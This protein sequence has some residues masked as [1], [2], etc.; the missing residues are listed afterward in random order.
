MLKIDN[1]QTIEGVQVYG[2]DTSLTKFYLLPDMP[3]FRINDDGIPAFTFLKYREP[4]DRPDGKKGGAFLVFDAEFVVADEKLVVIKAKLQEQ[5][6][7]KFPGWNPMPQVEIGTITW[8][9]GTSKLNVESFGDNFVEKVFNPGKP[10]LYGRNI[11]PFSV[12]LTVDGAQLFEAALQGKGGFVQVAYDLYCMVKLPP[13][14]GRIWFNSSNF[15][16]FAQSYKKEEHQEGAFG[17]ICDWLFGGDDTD[18]VTI[19]QT[20]SEYA[21]KY[22]WGGVELN[23]VDIPDSKSNEELQK[24]LRQ[25]GFDTLREIMKDQMAD[26]TQPVTDEQRKIPADATQF[27]QNLSQY[28]FS[29]YSQTFNEEHVVQWN[30]APQGMLEPITNLKGKDGKA[31]KWEDF[32]RTVDFNDPFFKTLEVSARV[33]ADFKDLPLD[34]IE[35]HMDY[36]EG[37][38]HEI[39]EYSFNSP[40]KLEKFRSYIENGKWTYKYWYQVNYKNESRAYKSEE[41]PTDEKF[42]TINVGET[43]ILAIDV[44][45]GDLNWS[46]V[47]QAQVKLTYDA[48]E[49]GVGQIEREYLLDKNNPN[50]SLREVVFAPVKEPYKYTVKYYMADGKEYQVTE[51]TSRSPQLYINDPFNATKTVSLRAAGDL[52]KDIQTIFVDVKYVDEANKYTKST[53]VALSKTQPFF[54]W[55]FPAIDEKAGQV[56]YKGTI[57]LKNGQIEEI[58]EAMTEDITIM[59]GRKIQDTL[60]V[61]VLPVGIDFNK[62]AL[63]VVSLSYE[64]QANDIVERYDMTFDGTAKT[65]QTWSVALKNKHLN[66]YTWNAV[67]YMNDG[68]D[69]KANATPQMTDSLTLPL[70]MPVSV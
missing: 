58:P 5:V 1:V 20:V 51:A 27:T 38:V 4:I 19:S 48:S 57:Q 32:A 11:T 69:R 22:N 42:L 35:L 68:T 13:I 41:F 26:K 52:D 33:N 15:S 53:T 36:N 10:S 37:N 18:T 47:S 62:V 28:K 12:E 2:D 44:L 49:G 66:K 60:D 34:S 31:F 59:V 9:K 8:T 43:G 23:F 61:K 46:Q 55:S 21:S 29:S 16:S 25:W 39:Q 54:D 40:D 6:N 63:V 67:F 64:D 3:R 30:L 70:R 65:P 14:T 24:Q 56:T 7:Q 17:N 45:P 50:H